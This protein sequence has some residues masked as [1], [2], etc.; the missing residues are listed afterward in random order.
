[1]NPVDELLRNYESLENDFK[2]FFPFAIEYANKL[3][4]SYEFI[5]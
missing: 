1:L 2:A 4:G 5:D 3:K